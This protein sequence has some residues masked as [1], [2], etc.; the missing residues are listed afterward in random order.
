VEAAK[1]GQRGVL[2]KD[3]VWRKHSRD[4]AAKVGCGIGNVTKAGGAATLAFAILAWYHA[5]GD[6]IEFTFGRKLLPFGPPPLR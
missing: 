1:R 5:A 3:G 4:P 6:I 2:P